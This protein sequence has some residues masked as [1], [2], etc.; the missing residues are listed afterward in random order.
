MFFQVI[1]KHRSRFVIVSEGLT[2]IYDTKRNGKNVICEIN[3]NRQFAKRKF[4]ISE[5]EIRNF[6]GR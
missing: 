3:S 5:L 2:V 1:S 4:V 6:R